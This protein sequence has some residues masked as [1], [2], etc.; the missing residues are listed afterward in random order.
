MRVDQPRYSI[1]NLITDPAHVVDR[2]AFWI[3][4]RPVVTL[5]ALHV[6]TLVAAAHCD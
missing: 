4:K 2:S 1:S 3:F 5:K 6:R